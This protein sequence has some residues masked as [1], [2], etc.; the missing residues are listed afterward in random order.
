M[1]PSK[2]LNV[3]GLSIRACHCD[4]ARAADLT[5]KIVQSLY[6]FSYACTPQDPRN[7]ELAFKRRFVSARRVC[8]R[9]ILVGY[10]LRRWIQIGSWK[11]FDPKTP[12]LK[13]ITAKFRPISSDV[14]K[15]VVAI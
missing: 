4:Q 2:W 1:R 7:R 13:T 15:A 6:P 12:N 8:I 11:L 3:A 9:R 5:G 10:I 14:V